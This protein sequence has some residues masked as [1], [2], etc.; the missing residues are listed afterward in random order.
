MYSAVFFSFFCM[1]FNPPG[2]RFLVY[3]VTMNPKMNACFN[4]FKKL[5]VYSV[6]VYY[7]HQKQIIK[8]TLYANIYIILKAFFIL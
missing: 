6:T 4:L 5:P 1:N 7:L 3:N 2:K 8:P